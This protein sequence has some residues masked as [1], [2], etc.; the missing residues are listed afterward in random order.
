MVGKWK[1]RLDND[2]KG[3]RTWRM[4]LRSDWIWFKDGG[5]DD[6]QECR[7]WGKVGKVWQM[8]DRN[9]GLRAGA[10]YLMEER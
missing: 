8:K 10:D 2:V 4:R 3:F 6:A 9:H 7:N 1:W 5:S